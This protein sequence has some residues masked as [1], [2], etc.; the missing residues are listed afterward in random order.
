[1]SDP[2]YASQGVREQ[3]Q[4]LAS[5]ALGDA[6]SLRARPSHSRPRLLPEPSHILPL[7]SSTAF[8]GDEPRASVDSYRPEVIDE[9]SEPVTPEAGD[10]QPASYTDVHDGLYS[11]SQGSLRNKQ[12]T[13]DER[14]FLLPKSGSATKHPS[15]YGATNDLEGQFGTRKVSTSSH[16]TMARWARNPIISASHSVYSFKKHINR[17][18]LLQNIVWNPVRALPAVLLGLLLNVLDAL[19]YGWRPAAL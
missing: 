15:H 7:D 16:Q 13:G 14:S 18:C 6:G 17:E 4:E 12:S 9:A 11:E 2:H 5:W 8:N 19:S 1:M 3:T 10:M